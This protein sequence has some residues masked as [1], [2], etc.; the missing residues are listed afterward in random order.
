MALRKGRDVRGVDGC[1]GRKHK[2]MVVSYVLYNFKT[3]TNRAWENVYIN[4][5]IVDYLVQQFAV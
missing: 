5:L 1:H 4:A 3:L 2:T